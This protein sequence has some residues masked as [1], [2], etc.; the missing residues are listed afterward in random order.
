MELDPVSEQD[1]SSTTTVPPVSVPESNMELDPVSEQDQSSPKCEHPT[2]VPL[3]THIFKVGDRFSS[4]K[5]LQDKIKVYENATSV[6]LSHRDSRTLEAARKR[7]PKRIEGA[8]ED[9]K[10]YT[11]HLACIFGGKKYMNKSSGKRA[12]QR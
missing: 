3:Q 2:P 12:Y 8:N 6:Q 7:V 1:Q 4:Y 9:L 11:I 5:A 10:Y